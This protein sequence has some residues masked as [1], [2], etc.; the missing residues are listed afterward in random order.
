MASGSLRCAPEP[1]ALSRSSDDLEEALELR[2]MSQACDEANGLLIQAAS[3]METS[4]R[5]LMH[6]LEDQALAALRKIL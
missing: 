5:G 1:G 6:A 3:A 2:R 4:E